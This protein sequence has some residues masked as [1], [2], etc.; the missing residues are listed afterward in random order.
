[1]WRLASQSQGWKV[2]WSAFGTEWKAVLKS[3]DK[4]PLYTI[5]F[6]VMAGFEVFICSFFSFYNQLTCVWVCS[7]FIQCFLPESLTVFLNALPRCLGYNQAPLLLGSPN[8]TTH[9]HIENRDVQRFFYSFVKQSVQSKI[10]LLGPWKI[11]TPHAPC[12]R[13]C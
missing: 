7:I 8:Y 11:S 10:A 2:A 6:I 12:V 3:H 13:N 5:Y 4:T 1:M 9:M